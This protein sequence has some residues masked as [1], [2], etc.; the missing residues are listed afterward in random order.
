MPGHGIDKT[1][2]GV[3]VAL[4]ARF[5]H[6]AQQEQSRE[7]KAVLQVLVRLAVRPALALAQERRQPQ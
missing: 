4:P 5:Q 1:V 7:L 3:G 6:V 2:A